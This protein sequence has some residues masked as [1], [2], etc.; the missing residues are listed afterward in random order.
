MKLNIKYV[1]GTWVNFKD[2]ASVKVRMLPISKSFGFKEDDVNG[3]TMQTAFNACVV[4]WKGF[5]DED[6]KEIKCTDKNKQLMF[7][8][9]IELVTFVMEEQ[10]KLREA[11]STSLKN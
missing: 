11:F 5:V 1:S 9:Y 2:D 3:E 8:A 6:D 7:N 10:N 4:D